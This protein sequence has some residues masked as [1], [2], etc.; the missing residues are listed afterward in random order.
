MAYY[1]HVGND[2]TSHG[3]WEI[4]DTRVRRIDGANADY[5]RPAD[6][7]V[8]KNIE[9]SVPFSKVHELKLRY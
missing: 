2:G 4:T 7:D 5:P 8:I 3:A 9:S 1:I 6:V